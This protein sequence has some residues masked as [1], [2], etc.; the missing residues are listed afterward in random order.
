MSDIFN[1]PKQDYQEIKTGQKRIYN[2]VEDWSRPCEIMKINNDGT[3]KIIVNGHMY[4]V[5]QR[6]IGNLC[7]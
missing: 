7:D 3:T 6:Y 4:D 5:A 1:K 2:G